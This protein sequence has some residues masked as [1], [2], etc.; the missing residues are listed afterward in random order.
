MPGV[1]VTRWSAKEGPPE[2]RLFLHQA[3][4][5]PMLLGGGVH[6]AEKVIVGF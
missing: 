5:K 6:G 4:L 2:H 3:K 1:S